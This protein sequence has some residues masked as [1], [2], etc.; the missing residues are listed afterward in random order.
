MF[1]NNKI[2][3]C[4]WFDDLAEEAAKF[5]TSTFDSSRIGDITL[6]TVDTPSNK[7]KGSVLTMEFEIGGHKF[8]GLN[9]GP[10]F[11]PNASISFFV[12]CETEAETDRVW[13]RLAKDGKVFMEL[14][15]YDWSEKYGW[16][17]DKYGISWQISLG[18]ISDT[19]Q[20]VTPSLLFTGKVLGN[21]E[22]AVHYYTSVFK[23]SSIEGILK[24]EEKEQGPTGLVKHAQFYLNGQTFMAM[25]SGVDMDHPF[26]EGISLMINCEDQEE[27]DYYW[28]KLSAVPESEQCGWVKDKFGVSWQVIPKILPELLQSPDRQKVKRVMEAMLKMKKLDIETLKEA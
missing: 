27:V 20:K 5:Y 28:E 21:A 25:D 26:T 10:M 24:Y 3:T 7:P 18:K 17:E 2:S 12:V 1:T 6:Y 4:L 14:N 13:A 16:V 15:K 19:K 23:N 8:V 11:K 22:D 9:G